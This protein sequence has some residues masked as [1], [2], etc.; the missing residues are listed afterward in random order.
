[1]GRGARGR[2]RALHSPPPRLLRHMIKK[3]KFLSYA[4]SRFTHVFHYSS[5]MHCTRQA[6]LARLTSGLPFPS[7]L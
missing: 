4:H 3:H 1:M 5:S 2:R 7:L 6:P